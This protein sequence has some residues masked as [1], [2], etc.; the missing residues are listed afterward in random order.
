MPKNDELQ[1]VTL[2]LRRGDYDQLRA[3]YPELGAALVIRKIVSNFV[4]QAD[5]A[6]LPN[7]EINL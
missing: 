1:K 6:E 4:D 5:V 2:N 3:L 7:V